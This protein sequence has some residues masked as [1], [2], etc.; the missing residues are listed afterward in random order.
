MQLT[1]ETIPRYTVL[2]RYVQTGLSL[3]CWCLAI[4]AVAL[5]DGGYWSTDAYGIAVGI[6]TFIWLAY[7]MFVPARYPKYANGLAAVVGEVLINIFWF[8]SFIASAA[9]RGPESCNFRGWGNRYLKD[10]GS[11]CK[12]AK[13]YIAF[14]AITWLF[15]IFSTFFVIKTS[16]PHFKIGTNAVINAPV[17]VGGTL[18]AAVA[19]DP[20]DPEAAERDL[21]GGLQPEETVHVSD[22]AE[23]EITVDPQVSQVDPHVSQV[24]THT[25]DQ[26]T[27]QDLGTVKMPDETYQPYTSTLDT[28]NK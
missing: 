25:Q 15:F 12:V 21:E 14:A 1:S 9:Q 2:T 13:A 20:E 22:E 26:E 8:T 4:S 3:L 6:L 10:W 19:S 27:A 16:I 11:S 24:T 18:G 5:I 23:K 17:L 7:V 28:H